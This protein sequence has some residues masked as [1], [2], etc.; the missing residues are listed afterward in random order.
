MELSKDD[1]YI[2]EDIFDLI[3]DRLR[4]FE[5]GEMG[6]DEGQ[7]EDYHNL[8]SRHREAAKRAG[9]WWAR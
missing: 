8:R 3:D 2:L 1:L 5:D 4:H 7:V 9:F 6:W